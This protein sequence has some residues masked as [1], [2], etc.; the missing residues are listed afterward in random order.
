MSRHFLKYKHTLRCHLSFCN[1]YSLSHEVFKLFSP[2]GLHKHLFTFPIWPISL[3]LLP[4]LSLYNPHQK[5]T[6]SCPII[7]Q[8]YPKAGTNIISSKPWSKNSQFREV[9]WGGILE[10]GHSWHPWD[11]GTQILVTV[12]SDETGW[13]LALSTQQV[14]PCTCPSRCSGF[15]AKRHFLFVSEAL[16]LSV[17]VKEK[18]VIYLLLSLWDNV[19]PISHFSAASRAFSAASNVLHKL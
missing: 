6:V 10:R 1:S 9:G 4:L 5:L 12:C 14:V 11:D 17:F 19:F 2:R 18:K 13:A 8:P 16:S 7:S 3:R 15:H